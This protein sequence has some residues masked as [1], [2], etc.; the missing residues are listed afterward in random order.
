MVISPTNNFPSVNQLGDQ[1]MA[2]V[3][4]FQEPIALQKDKHKNI[5]FTPQKDFSFIKNQ[6]SAPITG[7]EFFAASRYFP[8]VF[9]KDTEGN[10]TPM[11]M[12]TILGGEN[13]LTNAEGLWNDV[14]VPVFF[15]QYPFALTANGTVLI[16]EKAPHFANK[17]GKLLFEKDNEQSPELKSTIKFLSN[18]VLQQ[19]QTAAFTKECKEA[20]LI[21]P[22]NCTVKNKNSQTMLRGLYAIDEKKFRDLPTEKLEEWFRRG[23][24]G[25]VYAHLHSLGAL[26]KLAK[27]E[28]QA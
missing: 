12:L 6:N 7:N 4:I 28:Q 5:R 27:Q 2:A 8:V 17:D 25:W 18:I 24:I 20:G 22:L 16:D 9:T 21:E 26:E 19:K 15:R 10:F 13:R 14:Y 1:N 23:W 3:S 11:V